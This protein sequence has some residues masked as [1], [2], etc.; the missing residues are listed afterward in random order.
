MF[1][2][3]IIQFMIQKYEYCLFAFE[4]VN[5]FHLIKMIYGLTAVWN[6]P[7]SIHEN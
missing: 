6:M 1:K 2:E 4:I 5:R 7:K 3:V